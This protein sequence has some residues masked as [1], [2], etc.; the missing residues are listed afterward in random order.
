MDYNK[1][2]QFSKLM[3]IN[4][5]MTLSRNKTKLKKNPIHRLNRLIEKEKKPRPIDP[6]K[7]DFKKL[8]INSRFNK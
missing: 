4:Y 7:S 6:I 5:I 2:I 1:F 8:D 3:S